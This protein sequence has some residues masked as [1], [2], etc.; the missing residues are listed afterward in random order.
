MFGVVVVVFVAAVFIYNIPP[1][2]IAYMRFAPAD[3]I[4]AKAKTDFDSDT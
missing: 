4:M 1:S 3:L 2:M